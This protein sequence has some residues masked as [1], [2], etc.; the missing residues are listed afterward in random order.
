LRLFDA[1]ADNAGSTM[2]R[3]FTR[4]VSTASAGVLISCAADPPAD[5]RDRFETLTG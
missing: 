5:Y 2:A 1:R 3:C 4:A